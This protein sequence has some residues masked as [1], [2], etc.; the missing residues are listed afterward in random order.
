MSKAL[1]AEAIVLGTVD[2]LS[3]AVDP[4]AGAGVAAPIGSLY[5]R[6]NGVPYIKTGAGNTAWSS[7]TP[8]SPQRFRYVAN[9]AEGSSFTITLPAARANAG[10]MV[11]CTLAD[12]AAGLAFSLPTAGRTINDFPM[13]TS[14][15]LSNG[16]TLEFFVTDPT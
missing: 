15:D 16:D 11:F 14:G 6:T 7:F 4:T 3:G 10:Y 12:V 5:L 9:G 1:A 13:L 8:G 2:L